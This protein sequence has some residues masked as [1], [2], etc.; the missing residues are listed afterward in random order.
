MAVPCGTGVAAAGRGAG[1]AGRTLSSSRVLLRGGDRVRGAGALDL[2]GEDNWMTHHASDGLRFRRGRP[3]ASSL[4]LG[5]S[6]PV[7]KLAGLRCVDGWT[8]AGDAKVDWG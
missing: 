3:L 7:R 1:A 5:P 6:E 8:A 2:L 4:G